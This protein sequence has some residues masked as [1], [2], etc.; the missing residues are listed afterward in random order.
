V[1]VNL[2]MS[3]LAKRP[4]ELSGGMRKRVGVARAVINR[5]SIILYDEPTTGAGLRVTG[6]VPR[7]GACRV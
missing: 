7:G 3:A 2:P 6:R 5:P 1:L 4:A